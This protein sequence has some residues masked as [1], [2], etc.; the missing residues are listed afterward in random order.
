MISDYKNGYPKGFIYEGVNINN[1]TLGY[2]RIFDG[3]KEVGNL[4]WFVIVV[5]RFVNGTSHISL[6]SPTCRNTL[7]LGPR[8]LCWM[9]TWT[10]MWTWLSVPAHMETQVP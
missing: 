6:G 9:L 4:L 3:E 1:A 8:W 2:N 7:V 5:F 10:V